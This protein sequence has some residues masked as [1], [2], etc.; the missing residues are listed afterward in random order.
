MSNEKKR[1]KGLCNHLLGSAGVFADF[2]PPYEGWSRSN[3]NRKKT[4]DFKDYFGMSKA[5]TSS[6]LGQSK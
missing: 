2:E 6:N 1:R 4:H 5:G 3:G